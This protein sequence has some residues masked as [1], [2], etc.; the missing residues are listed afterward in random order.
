MLEPIQTFPAV[1]KISTEKNKLFFKVIIL[2]N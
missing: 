2:Y 1:S